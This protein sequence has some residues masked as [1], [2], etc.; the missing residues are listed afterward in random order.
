MDPLS[1]AL[2]LVK[3]ALEQVGIRYAVGGSVASSTRGIARATVDVDLVAAIHPAQTEALAKALGADWYADPAMIRSALQAGRSFNVIHIR[4]AQKV[5][6]F[7]AMTDFDDAQLE[8]ATVVPLG[9][10]RIPCPVATAEDILLAKLQWYRDG[11]EVSDR[12][13]YDIT[14][15]VETNP[16]LDMPYLES[17]AAR[18]G[19][20]RL[21]AKALA[22]AEREP[23]R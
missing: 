12:Q 10:E 7:P 23:R 9:A 6:I 20:G 14:G 11:G 13:W 4:T 2:S 19:V 5:D 18:L 16:A 8:R 1:E 22:D 3:A 17:W 15:I 21:L